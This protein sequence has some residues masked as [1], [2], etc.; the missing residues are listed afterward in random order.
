MVNVIISCDSRYKVNKE[1]VQTA[2]I[3]TLNSQNIKGPVEVEISIVG[4][5]KMHELNRTYRDL[6][7][8][9]DILT[10]A[11]EDPN[12][13]NLQVLPKVGFIASPD[14]V[15]RLGCILISYPHAI[16]DAASDGKSVDDEIAYLAEHGTKHLLGI[17][18]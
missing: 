11:L 14:K 16:D 5:R 17:H 8:A 18:H 12:P 3:S 9:P 7:Y 2:V 1:I 6:D 15:L 4:N 10:F 13:Q